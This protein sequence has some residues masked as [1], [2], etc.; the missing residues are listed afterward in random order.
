LIVNHHIGGAVLLQN[1][2]NFIT[3]NDATNQIFEMNRSLQLARWSASQQ[4]RID[5]ATGQSYSV[6]FMP[7]FIGISQEGDGY[8]NDQILNGLTPLPNEMAMGATW[9]PDLTAQVGSVPSGSVGPEVQPAAR[10]FF[11]RARASPS[12]RSAT[13]ARTFGGDPLGGN[14]PRHP[15]VPGAGKRRWHFPGNGGADRLPEV[16]TVRS[17]EELKNFGLAPFFAITPTVE[18]HTRD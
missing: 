6:S 11:G 2:D 17:F 7:L 12:G 16:A 3:G 4:P 9:N 1:N 10:A 14:G 18:R 8:P 5:P 15:G 13:W